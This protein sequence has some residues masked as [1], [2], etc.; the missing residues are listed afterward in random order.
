M[1]CA[2]TVC[3]NGG[4]NHHKEP[5]CGDACGDKHRKGAIRRGCRAAEELHHAEKRCADD[6]Y[7]REQEIE[8]ILEPGALLRSFGKAFH[9]AGALH[10]IYLAVLKE[11]FIK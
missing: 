5:R 9:K 8:G 6:K 2:D 1:L 3:E 7:D 11:V 10:G 4:Q